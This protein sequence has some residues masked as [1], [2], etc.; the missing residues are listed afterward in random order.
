MFHFS[1]QRIAW[2]CIL[3]AIPSCLYSGDS[4]ALPGNLIVPIDGVIRID[5]NRALA[6]NVTP[7]D[8]AG[9]PV[10][11]SQPGSYRLTGNLTVPD[12]ETTAIQIAAESVTLDLNGFSI[13]GP[14]VCTIN[15]TA[16]PTVGSGTGIQAGTEQTPRP[17]GIRVLNGSVRGM[18]RAAILLMG[19]GSFVERVSAVGNAGGGISVAGSVISSSA[20]QNGSFGIIA[21]TVRDSTATEN[22]GDGI[23]LDIGGVATG[24][25]SSF[26]GGF[27]IFVPFGTAT[28]N[29][30]FVNKSFGISATCPSSIVGNTVASNEGGGVEMKQDGCVAANNATRP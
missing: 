28:G 5:Q 17:R 1:W 23:L 4:L 30:L 16:C 6:G 13:I 26:N 22:A 2:S 21:T 12:I 18:G 19:D 20:V 7:G 11:I 14:A 8:A 3:A 15:P 24:N 25:V 27:G 9:F 29:T 10:T